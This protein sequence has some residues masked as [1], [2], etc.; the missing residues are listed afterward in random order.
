MQSLANL[1]NTGTK[2]YWCQRCKHIFPKIIR[3]ERQG[4]TDEEIENSIKKYGH[5]DFGR[6]E[7]KD[8]THTE[9]EI[10]F[11][12]QIMK[13]FRN[14]WDFIAGQAI[15]WCLHDNRTLADIKQMRLGG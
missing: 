5:N 3:R 10:V 12:R 9:F 7:W 13:H 6:V 11:N 2:N 15:A 8:G 1:I 14:V 4:M